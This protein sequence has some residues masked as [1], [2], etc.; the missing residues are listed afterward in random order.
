[1]QKNDQIFDGAAAGAAA[2][3][4]AA[5]AG[6]AA[7][8]AAGAAGSWACATG[9]SPALIT[10]LPQQ[11]FQRFMA[12][13]PSFPGRIEIHG[14]PTRPGEPGTLIRLLLARFGTGKF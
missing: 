2:V 1:M 8:A 10:K 9:V 12:L 11:I 5:A 7:G 14:H 4:G 6:K 3:A 13:L